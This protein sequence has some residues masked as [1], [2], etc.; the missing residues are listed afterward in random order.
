[1]RDWLKGIILLVIGNILYEVIPVWITEYLLEQPNP[2]YSVGLL[3]ENIPTT[4]DVLTG[5]TGFA[6]GIIGI[7]LIVY[8]LYLFVRDLYK[9]S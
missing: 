4:H 7:L 6:I 8:G 2:L 9:K 5:E 1:M 3:L